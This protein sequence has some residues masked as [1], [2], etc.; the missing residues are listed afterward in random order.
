MTT[1][2]PITIKSDAPYLP[3]SLR[4]MAGPVRHV[5]RFSL[6]ERKIL[7]KR[8]RIR[9]SRWCEEHRIVTMS[10][11]PGRWRNAV[12]PHVA[13]I[14]DASFFESV[15]EIVVV[16]PPQ[17]AKTEGVLNCIGY[18][19]DRAPGSAIMVYP[20][21]K[22]SDENCED[23][24]QP[25]IM[26]SRRL[27]S[28]TTGLEDDLAK[29]RIKLQHMPIYF[30]WARSA[31]SLAN[32]PCRY[33]VNDE[34]DKYP[35]TSGKRETSP[36]LL[37][38]ARLTTYQGQEKH[39]IISTPTVETG[40]VWVYYNAAQ[41]RFEYHVRCPV[42]GT[43]QLMEFGSLKW[44]RAPEAGPD[45]IYH[46]MDPAT[47]EAEKLAWYECV[48]C[49]A[50]WNDYDR[51]HAVRGGRWQEKETG[52]DLY[53]YL[54]TNRPKKIAF[55]Y[56][57]LI[58]PFVSMSIVAA[59][60]LR[61]LKDLTEFKDF[62]NKH[63][64][65]PW[66][67]III[68]KAEDEILAA[69]CKLPAQTVPEEALALTL[70]VDVQKY[71]FW[72]IVRA[73]AADMTSWL[74]H[75]GFL[76]NWEDVETSL[77]ET[78]YPVADS[79]RSLGIWRAAIDTGGGKKYETMTMTEETYFWIIKHRGRGGVGLW[80]TK[81]ASGTLPGMLSLGKIIPSTP[82][83][84][85]L[86]GGLRILS[87]DTAKAKD[88]FHH[89]L[90]LAEKEL[91]GGAYLHKDTRVDYAA[92]ILAEE[93]QIN[94]RGIEEWVNPHRRDNHLFDAEIL[95]AACVEMEFPGG[96]LR[97][98][99]EAARRQREQEPQKKPNAVRSKWMEG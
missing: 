93:K 73:W 16:A 3:P 43:L 20:D 66:K 14:M 83:G 25:M 9:P 75:Y 59:S 11:L 97:L 67:Q 33:A 48:H 62:Y 74:I 42:C 1:A 34:V 39:W 64:A 22:T 36:I 35:P 51:N 57:S 5:V 58:S 31:A 82:S 29:K 56:S 10:S 47:I 72:F 45:G 89:R 94:D 99:A 6:G 8:K 84:K 53:N 7:R 15:R 61:G 52:L 50:E 26:S 91:P 78:R 63:L 86:Q 96:G 90:S 81:G 24:V 41:V 95:A 28:Y 32:K 92:Q 70:G 98:V 46:S 54:K 2:Q 13:G 60:F 37:T 38:K 79:N 12:T 23:R 18:A 69:R 76:A 68:S 55:H 71:G 49:R 19:I 30:A 80:G 44:P 27:R 87:I 4:G 77:Y 88:Q 85:K 65:R 17:S 40:P 21:E